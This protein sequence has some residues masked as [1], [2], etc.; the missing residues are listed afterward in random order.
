MAALSPI[1]TGMFSFIQVGVL[2][3]GEVREP[4]VQVRSPRAVL[5]NPRACS[6]LEL[7]L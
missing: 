5:K 2:G 3:S 7:L 1:G 6:N 4:L